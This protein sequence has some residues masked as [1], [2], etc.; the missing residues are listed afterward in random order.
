MLVDVGLGRDTNLESARIAAPAFEAAGYNAMWT[1]ET[2]HDP[3]L[4]LVVAADRTDRLELGTSI[5]VAFARNPMTVANLG[6]DLQEFSRGR[7]VLGL[8]TQ[9]QPHIARRY[10]MPWSKPAA[11]IREFVCAL[12]TIW[13]CW[14]SGERLTFDGEFYSHTLMTP[15]FAPD[16]SVISEVG[17]PKVF[18]AGVGPKMTEVAG[19]VGDGFICHGF[20]TE[21]YLR[22]VTLPALERGRARAGMTLEGFEIVGP[23]FV[24]T[25]VDEAEVEA[26]AVKARAQLAFYGSTPAYLPVLVLHGWEDLG[27][28]LHRRTKAGDWSTLGDVIDDE[29]L[30][31]FAVI[32][33][34]GTIA[35]QIKA[36]YGD[37]VTRVRFAT[38]NSV[39]PDWW[40]G[41]SEELS[42]E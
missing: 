3:F 33:P 16:A 19:E 17:M 9:I 23:P 1:A 8:G 37:V 34:L 11:R 14:L 4:P 28:E 13:D 35:S 39:A 32:G 27:I 24:V 5:A 15:F 2:D 42:A 20:T 29:V 31:A 6:W 18:L 40:A 38:P 10:S 41:I 25:G 12:R 22:E 21:R 30:S 26:A 36:R 7:F